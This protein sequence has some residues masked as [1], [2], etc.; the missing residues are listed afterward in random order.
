MK[1]PF[2]KIKQTEARDDPYEAQHRGDPQHYA[3]VPAF[4]LILVMNVVIGNRKDRAIVK[5][6]QHHNH[7]CR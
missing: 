1:Q 5:Q 7:H 4:R 2:A 3:H 6:R